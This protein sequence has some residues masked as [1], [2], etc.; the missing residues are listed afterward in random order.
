[1][2]AKILIVDDEPEVASSLAQSLEEEGYEVITAKD[3]R[4]ALYYFGE[5]QPGLILLD[6]RFGPYDERMGLVAQ[7]RT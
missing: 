1:M 4:E 3:D 2:K 5:V 7:A 6:I